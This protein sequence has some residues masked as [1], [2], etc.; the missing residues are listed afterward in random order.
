MCAW[1]HKGQKRAS[2]TQGQNGVTDGCVKPCTCWGLNQDPL[3][4]QQV[5]LS[6]ESA[7]QAPVLAFYKC[8]SIKHFQDKCILFFGFY[9]TLKRARLYK[10]FSCLLIFVIIILMVVQH[11]ANCFQ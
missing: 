10:K 5:F 6:V 7:F 9:F 11:Y 8:I 3:E 4:K 2:D 1:Y